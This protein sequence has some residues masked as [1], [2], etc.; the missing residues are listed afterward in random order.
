MP[1]FTYVVSYKASTHVAQGS[2]SNFTGFAR[3]WAT[4]IPPEALPG[5]TPVLRVVLTQRAYQGDFVAVSGVKHVWRKTLDIGG[6]PLE[7]VAIQ[8]QQ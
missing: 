3:T 7:V 1:L 2:H 5:L 8:T 4:D 6:A